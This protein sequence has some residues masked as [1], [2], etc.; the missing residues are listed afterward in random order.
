MQSDPSTHYQLFSIAQHPLVTYLGIDLYKAAVP[1]HADMPQDRA[2]PS[3]TVP[4]TLVASLLTGELCSEQGNPGPLTV[5]TSCQECREHH[6]FVDPAQHLSACPLPFS[7]PS[8][9]EQSPS[10]RVGGTCSL[11]L[12]CTALHAPMWMQKAMHAVMDCL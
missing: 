7:T 8:S 9:P 3:A 12:A 2:G 10:N 5:G 4:I 6:I 1:F 11:S